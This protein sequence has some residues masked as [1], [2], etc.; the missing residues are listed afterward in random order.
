MAPV[1][2]TK[3]VEIDL[4]PNK[5]D[6][7]LLDLGDTTVKVTVALQTNKPPA[8]I[9][10]TRLIDKAVEPTMA[11]Y[12]TV[13]QSTVDK[14]EAKVATLVKMKD[15]DGAKDE[16][17]TVTHSVQNACN[18]LQDAVDRA[19]QAQVKADAKAD[20]N[21]TEARVKVGVAVTF[22]TI[23][24]ALDAT[25]IGL[26]MG[27]DVH[28]DVMIVKHVYDLGKTLY[29]QSK[30][31]AK[32]RKELVEAYDSY[33][34]S[35]KLKKKAETSTAADVQRR[36]SQLTR[37]WTSNASLA[38]TARKRYR[39]EVTSIRQ[40]LEKLSKRSVKLAEAVKSGELKVKDAAKAEE[41]A[42]KIGVEVNQV[43][44]YLKVCEKVSE[45]MAAELGEAFAKHGSKTKV[46]DRTFRERFGDIGTSKELL[47]NMNEFLSLVRE[48]SDLATA[49][50]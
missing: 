27:A 40:N 3:T 5:P 47:T 22:K 17:K 14:L 34:E 44:Q 29:D 41:K 20:E 11:R 31:E 26:T 25:R 37:T 32:L 42:K 7:K 2:T 43:Y 36:L 13:V 46:D 19:V 49:G 23:T 6:P 9:V 12:Q 15:L 28:A 48:I 1:V 39:D 8:P 45:T 4:C 33:I 21:L 50:V 18:S 16:A 30:D 10:M 38:E 24:I 35:R